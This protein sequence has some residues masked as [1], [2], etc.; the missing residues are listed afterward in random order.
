LNTF[1]ITSKSNHFTNTTT[2]TVSPDAEQNDTFGYGDILYYL[3]DLTPYNFN[4]NGRMS[5]TFIVSWKHNKSLKNI[6]H[7]TLFIVLKLLLNQRNVLSKYF[8]IL[9]TAQT[10]AA[11]ELFLEQY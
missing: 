6:L 1:Q 7:N 2:V 5:I 3:V 10:C 8:V 9:Y 4:T 11:I